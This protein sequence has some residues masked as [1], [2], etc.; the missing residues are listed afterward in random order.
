MAKSPAV[1]QSLGKTGHA[2]IMKQGH[3]SSGDFGDDPN[4]KARAGQNPRDLT[5]G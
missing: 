5:A 1:K 3:T 2:S 4:L